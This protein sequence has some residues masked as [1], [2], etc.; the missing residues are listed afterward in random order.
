[1]PSFLH[2]M[3]YQ[4][5]W[6]NVNENMEVT[7]GYYYLREMNALLYFKKVNF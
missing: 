4:D 2:E 6:F 3:K 7:S 1:M 5:D